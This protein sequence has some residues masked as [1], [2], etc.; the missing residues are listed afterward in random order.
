MVLIGGS[1]SWGTRCS[2]IKKELLFKQQKAMQAA[3]TADRIQN[4]GWYLFGG[5][6]VPLEYRYVAGE[7]GGEPCSPF[8]CALVVVLLG[9]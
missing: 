1:F 3:S 2:G 8:Q 4:K 9:F 6:V 7:G 5:P